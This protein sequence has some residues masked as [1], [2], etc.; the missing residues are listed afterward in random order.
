MAKKFED[1]ERVRCISA[2]PSC[3]EKRMSIRAIAKHLGVSRSYIHRLSVHMGISSGA[4]K[5]ATMRRQQ[6]GW[7]PL[8]TGSDITCEAIGMKAFF[9]D[10]NESSLSSFVVRRGLC[11]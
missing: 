6:A 1:A 10:Q 11:G 7:E 5:N 9:R 2:L 4:M 8:R 3:H